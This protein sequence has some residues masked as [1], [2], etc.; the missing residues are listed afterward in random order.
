MP[1]TKHRR[2]ENSLC[3]Y[4]NLEFLNG[5]GHF[6]NTIFRYADDKKLEKPL[7][8]Y[9]TGSSSEGFGYLFWTYCR[10]DS[11]IPL[12]VP[13]QISQ[14]FK[15]KKLGIME[16]MDTDWDIMKTLQYVHGLLNI[17]T[18]CTNLSVTSSFS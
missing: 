9:L 15:T 3:Q 2:L 17:T 6:D 8:L 12:V 14:S 11:I 5:T 7:L 10:D 13:N 1:K 18:L 4:T 16:K